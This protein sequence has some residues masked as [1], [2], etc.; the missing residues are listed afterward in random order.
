[1]DKVTRLLGLAEAGDDAARDL[2]VQ[3]LYQELRKLAKHAKRN[4]SSKAS[5]QTTEILNEACLRLLGATNSEAWNSRGHFF[6]AAAITM[7]RVLVDSARQRK[8]DKRGG[9]W[10]RI[11]LQDIPTGE[12]PIREDLIALDEALVNLERVD[13]DA[14]ELVHLRYFAGLTVEEAADVIGISKRS[15]E[16]LWHYAKAWLQTQIRKAE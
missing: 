14:Y 6:T 5:L 4:E 9:K 2:L 7:R 11:E 12:S 3:S 15:A 1:M 13:A 10:N 8:A 16:R